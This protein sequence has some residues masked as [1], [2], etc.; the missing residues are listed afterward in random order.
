MRAIP[1]AILLLAGLV[2][3]GSLSAC[4]RR[5]PGGKP[6]AGEA[7]DPAEARR[8]AEMAAAAPVTIDQAVQLA[9]REQPGTVI[10]VEL[11]EQGGRAVWEVEIVSADGRVV[12]LSV[13]ASTGSVAPASPR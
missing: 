12:E 10:E 3:A 8:K 5:E 9:T 4:A 2:G 13:D 7:A 11:E 1:G 6:A